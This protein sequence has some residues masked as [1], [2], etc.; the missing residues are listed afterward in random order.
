MDDRAVLYDD[1]AA[2]CVRISM[3][4]LSLSLSDATP[5]REQWN[6]TAIYDDFIDYHRQVNETNSCNVYIIESYQHITLPV[7]CQARNITS[8]TP[9]KK[10]S[11]ITDIQGYER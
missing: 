4:V 10:N 6:L 1:T 9:Q 8:F 3:V 11:T 2:V 5:L 7:P